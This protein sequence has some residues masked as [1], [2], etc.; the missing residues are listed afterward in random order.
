M[1]DSANY[2]ICLYTLSEY[3][4]TAIV[5]SEDRKFMRA[6]CY[7]VENLKYSSLVD[8]DQLDINSTSYLNLATF[9]VHDAHNTNYY[10]TYRSSYSY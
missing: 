3:L 9:S 6:Q 10:Q 8:L 1:S 2:I 5:D 7:L 4:Y